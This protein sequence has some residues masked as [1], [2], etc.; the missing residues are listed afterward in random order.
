MNPFKLN[1]RQI[2]IVALLSDIHMIHLDEI[3]DKG[4]S[5]N[6]LDT[7]VKKNVLDF[8]SDNEHYDF[9]NEFFNYLVSIGA[10]PQN[11]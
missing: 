1:D 10:L 3:K 2:E 11:W 6:R 9:S 8:D 7:L 4:I 5:R